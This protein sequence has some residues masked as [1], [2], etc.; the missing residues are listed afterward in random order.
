MMGSLVGARRAMI[1]GRRAEAEIK[2]FYFE[3]YVHAEKD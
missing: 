2:R 1:E 3:D